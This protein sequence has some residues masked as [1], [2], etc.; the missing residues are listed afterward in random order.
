MGQK[1][2][3]SHLEKVEDKKFTSYVMLPPEVAGWQREAFEIVPEADRMHISRL[4]CC[5]K[6]IIFWPTSC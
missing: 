4:L 2:K 6:N 5:I 3:L 1:I